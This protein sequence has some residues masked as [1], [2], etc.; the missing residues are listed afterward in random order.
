MAQRYEMSGIIELASSSSSNSIQQNNDL[1][2]LRNSLK[3]LNIMP[4]EE[5]IRANVTVKPP[6]SVSTNFWCF[7][8]Y[9][10]LNER[11]GEVFKAEWRQHAQ[12]EQPQLFIDGGV[13]GSYEN[14]RY[15][16][17]IIGNINRN[18]VVT[19]VRQ[20]IGKGLRLFQ[21]NENIYLECLSD[22]ALFV[23]CPFFAKR[24]GDHLA[25]VYK[26]MKGRQTAHSAESSES[27]CL[28]DKKMFDDLLNDASLR[29]YNSLYALN[30]FCQ[31]RIS[32][33]KGWGQ[34]YRRQTITSC[35]MWIELQFPRPLQILDR[36]LMESA[37]EIG[38]EEVHSFS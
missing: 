9:Y 27:I 4:N 23:Q 29:G 11:V 33:V 3:S 13:S 15:C 34:Q 7:V 25:T 19:D 26:L 14:T 30:I 24:N 38:M 37:S 18:P 21:R 2:I 1:R 20:S 10:E 12:F 16:L 5:D 35:P 28:F 22:S 31:C 32:F 8:Y 36:A 17:G 6:Y